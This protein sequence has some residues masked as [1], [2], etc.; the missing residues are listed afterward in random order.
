MKRAVKQWTV[1]LNLLRLLRML[2]F[3]LL[4]CLLNFVMRRKW[5]GRCERCLQLIWDV[6]AIFELTKPFKSAANKSELV[7]RQMTSI[8]VLLNRLQCDT[9]MESML[10]S[11]INIDQ[12]ERAKTSSRIAHAVRLFVVFL[13]WDTKTLQKLLCTAKKKASQSSSPRTFW[14]SRWRN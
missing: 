6:Q 4:C 8:Y 10:Q 5:M 1:R 2:F 11:L 9:G 7:S 3:I 13:P 14:V 12:A